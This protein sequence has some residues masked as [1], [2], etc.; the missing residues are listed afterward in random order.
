[1]LA[2][3]LP[4]VLKFR[5][6]TYIGSTEEDS[7]ATGNTIKVQLLPSNALFLCRHEEKSSLGLFSDERSGRQVVEHSTIIRHGKIQRHLLHKEYHE[8]TIYSDSSKKPSIFSAEC[9]GKAY[10]V[11][12]PNTI[13]NTKNTF[14]FKSTKNP[15][16][17][18]EL[19]EIERKCSR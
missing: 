9:V 17:V 1:M 18:E 16:P 11:L 8:M 14:G 10:F 3:G 7:Q 4:G 15:P 12:N 6:R 2:S 13:S 5:N 19:K